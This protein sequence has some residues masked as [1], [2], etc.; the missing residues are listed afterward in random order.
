MI[1]EKEIEDLLVEVINLEAKAF[2]E[3]LKLSRAEIN[4]SAM[5][6]LGKRYAFAVMKRRIKKILKLNVAP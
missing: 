4:G 2:D 1:D 5:I 3:A 6:E